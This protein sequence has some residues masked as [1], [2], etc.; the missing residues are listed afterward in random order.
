[1]GVNRIARARILAGAVIHA[2][3]DHMQT[4]DMVVSGVN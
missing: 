4:E 1:M 3:R 2:I